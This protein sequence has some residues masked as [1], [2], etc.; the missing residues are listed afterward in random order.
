[1]EYALGSQATEENIFL[2]NFSKLI[3]SIVLAYQ[4]ND[5]KNMRR[6]LLKVKGN[7]ISQVHQK[8]YFASFYTRNKN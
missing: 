8:S 1:M 6:G 3:Y 5:T 4:A 7:K 2:Q